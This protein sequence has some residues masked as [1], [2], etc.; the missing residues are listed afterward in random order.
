VTG[1]VHRSYIYMTAPAMI[2]LRLTQEWIMAMAIMITIALP[3]R[4]ELQKSNPMM[5]LMLKMT[6]P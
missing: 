2:L 6:I 4:H 5:T 1:P 3:M